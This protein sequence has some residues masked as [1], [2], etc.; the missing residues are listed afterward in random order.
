MIVYTQTRAHIKKCGVVFDKFDERKE[1]H[2]CNTH[3]LKTKV[4]NKLEKDGDDDE[5]EEEYHRL[6]SF[7][8]N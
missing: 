7:N 2:V 6:R 8:A 5:E 4:L 1:T 3:V